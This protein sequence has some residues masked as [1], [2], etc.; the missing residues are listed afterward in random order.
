MMIMVMVMQEV[1]SE[2]AYELILWIRL[3]FTTRVPDAGSEVGEVTDASANMYHGGSRE[4]DM[5]KKGKIFYV[6]R[7]HGIPEDP[8]KLVSHAAAEDMSL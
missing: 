4:E 3:T 8:K 7:R 5:E 1:Q 2:N 6:R